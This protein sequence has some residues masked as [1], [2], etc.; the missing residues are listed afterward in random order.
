MF[1]PFSVAFILLPLCL[2]AIS[3]QRKSSFLPKS[4]SDLDQFEDS[5]AIERPF[6]FSNSSYVATI[7][8][9]S[10]GKVYAVPDQRMGVY[11]PGAT[12]QVKFKIVKGDVKNFFKAESRQVG[13]FVFL[14]LRTRPSP[15][16]SLNREHTEVFELLVTAKFQQPGKNLETRATVTVIYTFVV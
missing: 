2:S 9:N 1:L 5:Q 13:N 10:R 7:P 12:G 8:E 15:D 3:T 4:V 14:R 11:L 16:V 6:A